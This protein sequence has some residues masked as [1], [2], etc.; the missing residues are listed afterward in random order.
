MPLLQASTPFWTSVPEQYFLTQEMQS[1]LFNTEQLCDPITAQFG[2][3]QGTGEGGSARAAKA[4]H[5][6][7][8][9]APNKIAMI[10]SMATA[11]LLIWQSAIS[12]HRL[13]YS[14]F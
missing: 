2:H 1:D 10:L 12:T 11:S 3:S 5:T 13:S 9:L 8:K 14:T 7:K 6:T 4:K